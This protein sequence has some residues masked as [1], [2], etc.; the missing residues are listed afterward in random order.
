M[1]SGRFGAYGFVLNNLD[2][3]GDW[4]NPAPEDWPTVEVRQITGTPVT[5]TAI[6]DEAADIALIGERSLRLRS[7]PPEICFVGSTELSRDALIHPY[8]APAASVLAH[9][10]GWITLHAGA[11]EAKGRAWILTADRNGGKSTTLAA[12]SAMGYPVLADDLIV[13]RDGFALAGPRS[14]DLR[15]QGQFRN[16]EDLGVLGERRRWRMRL[17]KVPSEMPV[18][19][20]IKLS[21][22]DR[23]NVRAISVEDRSEVMLSAL[24]MPAGP[25]G[26][27]R[28][29]SLRVFEVGRPQGPLGSTTDLVER[30]VG[31][32]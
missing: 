14:L 28:L 20:V 5:E 32:Q 25:K 11:F 27:L 1:S 8:L 21:W 19:G 22:L 6:G 2:D 31:A 10:R 13:I 7:D 30:V 18:A 15:E 17:P 4:L 26:M 29:L 24:S 16:A 3:E 23:A 12:L 9:W